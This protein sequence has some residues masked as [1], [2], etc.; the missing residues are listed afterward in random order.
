MSADAFNFGSVKQK[1]SAS[2][3]LYI[4]NHSDVPV[5]YQFIAEYLNVFSFDTISGFVAPHSQ[6]H[7]TIKSR[8]SP[9][10]SRFLSR[11]FMNASQ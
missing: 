6:K 5:P 9:R 10:R 8:R 7:V 2:R 1:E 4:K 11:S 3:V